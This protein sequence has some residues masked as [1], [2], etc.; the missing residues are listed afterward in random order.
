VAAHNSPTRGYL[1][2][3]ERGRNYLANDCHLQYYSQTY[4]DRSRMKDKLKK[5]WRFLKPPMS[6]KEARQK[7]LAYLILII[8]FYLVRDVILYIVLPLTACKAIF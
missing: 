3:L 8:A 4:E 5:I 2:G 1:L 6:I 7:G